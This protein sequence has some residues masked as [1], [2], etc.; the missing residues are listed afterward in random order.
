LYHTHIQLYIHDVKIKILFNLRSNT[1]NACSFLSQALIAFV[2]FAGYGYRPYGSY[3]RSYGYGYPHYG[4]RNFGYGYG[5]YGYGGYGGYG[6]GRF[7]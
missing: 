1:A 5:G 4:Y 7:Y 6:Y 2:P 3:Y